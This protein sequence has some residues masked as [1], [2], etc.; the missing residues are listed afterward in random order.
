MGFL[1]PVV[2]YLTCLMVLGFCSTAH[3]VQLYSPDLGVG[4]GEKI[5]V[6]LMIDRVDNLAG[7][8][9][10]LTYDTSLLT[11][12]GSAKTE[13]SSSLM[14]IVN[15]R[16]PGVLIIV[17]A[18]ARGIK[19]ELFSL[20]DLYFTISDRVKE[21]VETQIELKE[22]QMMGDDLKEVGFT[23]TTINIKIGKD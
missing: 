14:H 1:S 16:K 15:D 12:S 8:K 22:I 19:G 10:V 7:I 23:F 9:I 3:G 13:L 18:G 6:P 21:S 20:F 11:Y 4:P 2:K 17:M 5:K